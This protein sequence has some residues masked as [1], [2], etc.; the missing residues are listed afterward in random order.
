[1][2]KA[3]K[4]VYYFGI[5]LLVIAAALMAFPNTLL[6]M[7]QIAPTNEIWIRVLGAVV[8]DIG[9]L[10]VFMAPANNPLF[11]I[12]TVY[13]RFSILL[14]FILFVALNMAPVQLILFGLIDA[15]GGAWT[16]FALR[17]E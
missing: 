16:Y 12:L 3:S 10:Y 6:G 14:W 11:M 8:F 1:M 13:V 7:F 4:T 5:Y 17:K 9:I 15:A 2:T